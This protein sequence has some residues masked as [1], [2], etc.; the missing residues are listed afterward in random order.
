MW[1]KL[2]FPFSVLVMLLLALPFAT[3]QRREGG[4]SAKIFLGI[5]LGLTFNFIGRMVASLGALNEWQPLLSVTAIPA[6]FLGLASVMLWWTER[7]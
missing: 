7:R 6:L 2:V 1:S 3:H 5:V 4:V